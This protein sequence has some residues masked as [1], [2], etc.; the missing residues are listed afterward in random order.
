MLTDRRTSTSHP[1]LNDDLVSK[2][3]GFQK[4]LD[5]CEVEG[6]QWDCPRPG[7]MCPLRFQISYLPNQT[8]TLAI[9]KAT[10]K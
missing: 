8:A 2:V 6:S 7:Q 3:T 4:M 10:V 9:T 5:S 1:Y